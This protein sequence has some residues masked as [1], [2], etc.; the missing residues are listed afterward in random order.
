MWNVYD[1][2]KNYSILPGHQGAITDVHYSADGGKL[3]T[4]STDKSVCVW[5]CRAGGRI[6]KLIGHTGIVNTCNPSMK[7]SRI[8]CR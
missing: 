6:K 7:D 8:I 4:S 3:Y 2:C 5:D 1:D